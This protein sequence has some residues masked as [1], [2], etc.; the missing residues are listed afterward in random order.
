MKTLIIIPTIGKNLDNLYNEEIVQKCITSIEN[1]TDENDYEI[2]LAINDYIGFAYGVNLGL[3]E[4]LNNPYYQ[5]FDGVAIITDDV[6]ITDKEWLTLFRNA[7]LGLVI[8]D[9]AEDQLY[10]G[11]AC[12]YIPKEIIEKVGLFDEQ[13]RI[14][15]WEDIDWCIRLK[16]AGYKIIGIQK[17][18]SS[19]GESPTRKNAPDWAKE[20]IKKNKERFREKWK[21]KPEFLKKVGM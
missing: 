7:G 4:F 10:S 2:Y 20:E 5:D 12:C 21:N 3:H 17:Q 15:E 13:F 19:H 8:Q 16:Q 18:I 6:E 11:M 9:A 14:A 1:N